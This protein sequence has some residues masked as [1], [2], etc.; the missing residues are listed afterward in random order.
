MAPIFWP[1]AVLPARDY[2]VTKAPATVK[3]SPS[4]DG[5]TQRVASAAG[6]WRIRM[7]GIALST[8]TRIKVW[9]ALEGLIEGQLGQVVVPVKDLT[10]VPSPATFTTG[11][12]HS[13]GA[14]FSDGS[15][16]A[17]PDYVARIDGALALNATQAVIELVDGD[18][19]PEP[20]QF[21]SLGYH[22]YS[23]SSIIDSTA[24][25]V[26]VKIWPPLRKAV[27]DGAYC[28]FTEP[29]CLCRLASDDAMAVDLTYGRWGFADL[30]WIED[31]SE[32]V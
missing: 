16:Y 18:A 23:I 21:F 29:W 7:I 2:S 25:T 5:V 19:L 28:N 1:A 13:D 32:P 20:G 8:D 30:D 17:Q 11:I 3:G 9:R 12:T 15:G 6:R 22:L 31:V 27:I 14:L 10:R 24:T 4:L 26:T